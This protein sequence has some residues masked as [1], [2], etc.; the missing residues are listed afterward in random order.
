MAT[1]E[2]MRVTWDE[3]EGWLRCV[4]CRRVF[5]GSLPPGPGRC[6]RCDSRDGQTPFPRVEAWHLVEIVMDHASRLRPDAAQGDREIVGKLAAAGLA[7]LSAGDVREMAADARLRVERGGYDALADV[8]ARL[9]ERGANSEYAL[10]LALELLVVAGQAS[11]EVEAITV[12][13]ATALEA[14]LDELWTETLTAFGLGARALGP[15]ATVIR[16]TTVP[17]QRILIS[18]VAADKGRYPFDRDFVSRWDEVLEHRNAVVHGRPFS[19]SSRCAEDAVELVA[20]A[21][22]AF[23]E[24]NNRMLAAAEASE[25]AAG[26][27]TSDLPEPTVNGQAD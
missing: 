18:E 4:E 21:V 1:D 2:A 27:E 14:L 19:V 12:L 6:P 25:A 11:P 7:G 3:T 10:H 8:A 15:L 13:A 26:G 20:A 17:R 23:A 22:G 24:A 5:R 9:T 16:H